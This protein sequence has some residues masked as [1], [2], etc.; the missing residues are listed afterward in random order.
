[1]DPQLVNDKGWNYI[2]DQRKQLVNERIGNRQYF[3]SEF[4]KQIVKSVNRNKFAKY[5]VILL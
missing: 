4:E 3:Y 2:V 5:I 1:M